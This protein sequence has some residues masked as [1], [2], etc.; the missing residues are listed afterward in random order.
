[1]LS[2]SAQRKKT[3]QDE[4][5]EGEEMQNVTAKPASTAAPSQGCCS[6]WPGERVRDYLFQGATHLEFYVRC[7]PGPKLYLVLAAV[8]PCMNL[9]RLVVSWRYDLTFCFIIFVR[10]W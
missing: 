1:M 2:D 4:D 3:V 5:D 6:V 10:L 8:S 7:L 9:G